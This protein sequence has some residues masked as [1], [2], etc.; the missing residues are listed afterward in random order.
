MIYVHV[1][2]PEICCESAD[3]S[4]EQYLM[5][6]KVVGERSWKQRCGLAVLLAMAETQT[7]MQLVW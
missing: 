3:N 7:L 4:T 1:V 2:N 6:C 5:I